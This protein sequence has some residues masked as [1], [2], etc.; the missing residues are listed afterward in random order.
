MP[1]R[2]GSAVCTLRAVIYTVAAGQALGRGEKLSQARKADPSAGRG[3]Y[4]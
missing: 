2:T 3:K 1:T 4:P